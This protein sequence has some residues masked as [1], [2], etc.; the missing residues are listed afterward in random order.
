MSDEYMKKLFSIHVID[1]DIFCLFKCTILRE[2][3]D[4]KKVETRYSQRNNDIQ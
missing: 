1:E 3:R 2:F 4:K